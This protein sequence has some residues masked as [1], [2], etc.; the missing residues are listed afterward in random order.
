MTERYGA[1]AEGMR[2]QPA[3]PQVET[4]CTSTAKHMV[5][6]LIP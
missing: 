5:K 1:I 6:P 4:Y 3:N 2:Q